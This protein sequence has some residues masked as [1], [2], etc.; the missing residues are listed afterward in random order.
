MVKRELGSYPGRGMIREMAKTPRVSPTFQKR[1]KELAMKA[2]AAM[3]R[4][5]ICIEV[6]ESVRDARDIMKEWEIRHLP[7][8]E[9]G[10]LVGILSDRDLLILGE[11]AQN[12]DLL[13]PNVTV[14]EAMTEDPI[15]CDR[16][17]DLE[18]IGQTML[19][20]KIDSLPIVAEDGELIGLI[21]SSDLIQ[22]LVDRERLATS[23]P[24][25]FRFNLHRKSKKTIEVPANRT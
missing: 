2:D 7:V 14:E 3:T 4:N 10:K 18:S 23:K 13:L 20:E 6:D 1:K 17:A 21:T 22:L 24:M 19:N 5:V 11:R 12:G 15:T 8:T 9:D 25:S 16:F